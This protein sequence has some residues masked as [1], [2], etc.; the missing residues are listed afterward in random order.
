MFSRCRRAHTT[1]A[2]NCLQL[3]TKLADHKTDV[4]KV[5]EIELLISVMSETRLYAVCSPLSATSS[6]I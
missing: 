6:R 2:D 5:V 4:A 1:E 3:M